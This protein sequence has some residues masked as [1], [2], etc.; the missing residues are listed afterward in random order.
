MMKTISHILIFQNLFFSVLSETERSLAAPEVD[1]KVT[2]SVKKH[3]HQAMKT[4]STVYLLH[5]I[6]HVDYET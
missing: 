5:K 1:K 6:N 4:V 2:Q 3:P